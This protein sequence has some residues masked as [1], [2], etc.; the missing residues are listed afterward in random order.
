LSVTR[1]L[2]THAERLL[3]SQA[4]LVRRGLIAA[5]RDRAPRLPEIVQIESTNICNARC[6]F[7]PRDEMKRR[8]GVMDADLYRKVVDDCVALGIRH[9]R[10]HNYGEPFVDRHLT[11]KVAYAKQRGIAEVGVISNGSLIDEQVARGVIE[12]GLDAINISVD[13]S[14]RDVFER[15]RVGLKY[16]Q[17]IANI[18]RLVRIRGELGR[19]H[20]K[21][22]LSFVRQDNSEE[23]RAFIDHWRTVADKIHITDL[24]NWAGTLNTESD[25]RYP[26]YRQWLTF[27]VLW[28]GRVSLCCA[29]FDGRVVLGDVRASSIREIWEGDAYRRVR[30]EHLESGGP[31]I[32]RACD[33]PRKDSPL[34][35]GKIIGL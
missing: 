32:C 3:L 12:A 16:D 1:T 18:E 9:V 10:L 19:T 31:A 14:G 24:H 27:T 4:K 7:C 25:V 15:T 23:E 29:D 28:D 22:I 21:L 26:C 5:G 13:A 8:Q 33:L 30:R 35:I 6:V 2:R 34:W 17:V 20:P 11:D